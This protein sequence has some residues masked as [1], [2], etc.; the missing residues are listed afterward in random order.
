MAVIRPPKRTPPIYA[1]PS[2]QTTPLAV[3]DSKDVRELG[4]A[5]VLAEQTTNPKGKSKLPKRGKRKRGN[6]VSRRRRI[7]IDGGYEFF[8]NVVLQPQLTGTDGQTS[9]PDESNSNH[10]LGFNGLLQQ[11]TGITN[12]ND[13]SLLFDGLSQPDYIEILDHDDFYFDGDF[14]V[15]AFINQTVFGT[16]VII[17]QYNTGGDGYGFMFRTA[18]DEVRF[19][20]SDDGTTAG[21]FNQSN[22]STMTINT[23]HHVAFSRE[24][25]VG[26][27]FVDGAM[28][29]EKST[30]PALAAWNAISPIRIGAAWPGGAL[31]KY[32]GSMDMIRVHKGVAIYTESFDIPTS[33][34]PT[35]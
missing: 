17:G 20:I 3:S 18:V 9:A 34:Y 28:S 23:W 27:T 24:G 4:G 5:V 16:H 7:I 15:E 30:T 26:R 14:T 12:I 25:D 2:L 1:R 6:V 11:D 19:E 13:T 32:N 33:A 31:W 8:D 10:T 35:S 29:T 22:T 21:Y